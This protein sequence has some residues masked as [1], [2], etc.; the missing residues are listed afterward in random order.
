MAPRQKESGI[1]GKITAWLTQRMKEGAPLYFEHRSGAGGFNYRKGVP[2][3]WAAVNG[4]HIE[5]EVKTPDG[6]LSPL[7][8][9]FRWRCEEIFHCAYIAPRSSEEAIAF[10][11]RFLTRE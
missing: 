4:A 3:L 2:D 7:Q 6:E 8:E 9:K 1:A 11:E 10:L 5:I